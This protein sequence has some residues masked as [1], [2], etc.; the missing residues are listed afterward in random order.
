ME[1]KLLSQKGKGKGNFRT[2]QL[3]EDVI[4]K[5]LCEKMKAHHRRKG[6]MDTGYLDLY[7]KRLYSKDLLLIT[8]KWLKEHGKR[9][10]K[11]TE[12]VRSWGAPRNK[13]YINAKTHREKL[14]EIWKKSSK[15]R[16]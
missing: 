2:D 9:L 3:A 1:K 6:D 5:T 8:N 12:T 4:F 13:C 16:G 10:I 15:S 7:D 11:S 14:L